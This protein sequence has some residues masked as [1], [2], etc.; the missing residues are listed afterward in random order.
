MPRDDNFST[1]RALAAFQEQT[2]STRTTITVRYKFVD[3]WHVFQSDQVPG[4]YVASRDSKAA[5]EDVGPSIKL[6][7]KLNEGVECDVAPEL[8]FREFIASLRDS[9]G[10]IEAPLVMSN[11]RFVLSGA[12]A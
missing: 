2:M 8:P 12:H 3:D 6:L 10:T 5:Y 1:E 7:M 11:K 9:E 4:L